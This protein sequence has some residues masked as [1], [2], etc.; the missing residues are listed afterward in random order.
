[1]GLKPVAHVIG[2]FR[3]WGEA[4]GPTTPGEPKKP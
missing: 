4:G 3:A 2:G 1:M